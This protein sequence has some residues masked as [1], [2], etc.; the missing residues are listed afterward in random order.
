VLFTPTGSA[1]ANWNVSGCSVAGMNGAYE[2][3]GS[4]KGATEGATVNFTHTGSTGQGTLK[5]GGQNAGIEG[6]ITLSGRAN[7]AQPFTP[8]GLT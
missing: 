2:T 8:L 5:I 1:F 3:T 7:S 4:V 6:T